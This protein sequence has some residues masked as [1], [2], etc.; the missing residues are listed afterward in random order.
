MLFS[1][2]PKGHFLQCKTHSLIRQK[3]MYCKAAPD[4]TEFIRIFP[5][6]VRNRYNNVNAIPSDI[7]RKGKDWKRM[8]QGLAKNKRQRTSA[9]VSARLPVTFSEKHKAAPHSLFYFLL[10]VYMYP[11]HLRMSFRL[12]TA[13]RRISIPKPTYSALI[14]NVSL[15]LRRVIIS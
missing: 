7:T 10:S 8:C 15:G 5:L 9:D 2:I 1:D 12:A 14:M 11:N 3:G 6:Q 13:I 4:G